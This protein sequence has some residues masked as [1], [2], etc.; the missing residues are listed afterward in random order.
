[1]IT[2]ELADQGYTCGLVGKL[3]IAAAWQGTEQRTDDGYGYFEYS[4]AP[5]QR[6]VSGNKYLEWILEQGLERTH[7][8]SLMPILENNSVET[9]REFVRS[10]FYD[11]INQTLNIYDDNRPAIHNSSYATMYADG[12]YKL[13]GSFTTEWISGSFTICWKIPMNIKIYGI[14]GIWRS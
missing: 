4:H 10:E 2:R 11:C 7:G 1:L 9:H 8:K 5:F 14:N 6:V 3:H 12:R 13:L